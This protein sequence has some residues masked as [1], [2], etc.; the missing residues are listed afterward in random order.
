MLERL[1]AA[2][3]VAGSPDVEVCWNDLINGRQFDVTLR[4]RK[5]P[6]DYLTVIECKD[7]TN[8]VPAEKVEAFVTKASDAGAN[9]AVM[10]STAGYQRAALTVAERHFVRLLTVE[11]QVKTYE[12]PP[13]EVVQGIAFVSLAFRVVGSPDLLD[14][15]SNSPRFGYLWKQGRI[16]RGGVDA[17]IEALVHTLRPADFTTLPKGRQ[18]TSIDFGGEATL[19]FPHEDPVRVTSMTYARAPQEFLEPRSPT[20]E[21]AVAGLDR[22][23]QERFLLS[24]VLRDEDDKEL[25]ENDLRGLPFG[26]DTILAE[27]TFY[28]SP[29]LGFYYYLEKITPELLTWIAIETYQHDRLFQATFTQKPEYAKGMVA[30]DDPVTLKRMRR[31]LTDLKARR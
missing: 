9:K 21:V 17:T 24:Y 22:F 10:V 16:R 14:V 15:P 20:P 5:G 3:H 23:L 1:V 25:Q 4:F 7:L 13:G 26:F 2:M 18:E 6:H 27:G 12:P 19:S 31:M 11:E 30:V 29:A 8:A 28:E